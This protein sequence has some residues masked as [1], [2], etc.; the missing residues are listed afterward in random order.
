MHSL[1]S[2]CAERLKDQAVCGGQCSLGLEPS[3][4]LCHYKY[5]GEEYVFMYTAKTMTTFS[6]HGC[7][8]QSEA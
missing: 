2:E 6:L 7:V 1:C 5:Y 4:R 8:T 3:I